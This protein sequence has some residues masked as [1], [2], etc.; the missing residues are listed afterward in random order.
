MRKPLSNKSN[1]QQPPN[2]EDWGQG[3]NWGRDCPLF[4]A[5]RPFSECL[6]WCPI[7]ETQGSWKLLSL[8]RRLGGGFWF[9]VRENAWS[10]WFY[11]LS[12]GL[13]GWY[14]EDLW[15]VF[16]EFCETFVTKKVLW[17]RSLMILWNKPLFASFLK[18]G[19]GE[20]WRSLD[21]YY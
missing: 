7:T 20:K 6:D 15:K 14:E 9:W 11:W 1:E 2:L 12:L 19:E 13:L 8:L 10:K 16:K 17:E 18:R 5:V 4:L 3:Y 21:L